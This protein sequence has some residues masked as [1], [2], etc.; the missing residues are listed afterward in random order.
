[1]MTKINN[2]WPK[3]HSLH[4]ESQFFKQNKGFHKSL[5]CGSI[6]TFKYRENV[7]TSVKDDWR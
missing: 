7:V 3:S 5:I 2:H 4:F 1:M 6:D